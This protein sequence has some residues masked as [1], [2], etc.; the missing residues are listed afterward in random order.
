MSLKLHI[1]ISIT[2]PQFLNFLRKIF[3][4]LSEFFTNISQKWHIFWNWNN[5][6]HKIHF[7]FH[8]PFYINIILC[9]QNTHINLKNNSIIFFYILFKNSQ[10]K[11]F[12]NTFQKASQ[13]FTK[14]KI[15]YFF[16]K[17][18]NIIIIINYTLYFI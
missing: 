12:F 8:H 10:Y 4:K 6:F 13:S 16:K 14:M 17:I 3:N 15:S 7:F 18:N 11:Q 1:V 5:N 2:S 9:D